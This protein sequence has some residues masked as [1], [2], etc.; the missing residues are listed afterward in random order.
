MSKGKAK[1]TLL[2]IQGLVGHKNV[3]D[4]DFLY[5]QSLVKAPGWEI[6]DRVATPDGRV[7]RYGLAKAAVKSHIGC[8]STIAQ[9]IT[10]SHPV[11]GSIGDRSLKVTVSVGAMG[12]D[13]DGVIDEDELRGGH[14][15][16]HDQA[17]AYHIHNRGIIGNTALAATG[18]EITLYLDAALVE[19][20]TA[21]DG[22]EVNGN[23]YGYVSYHDSTYTSVMGLPN[24]N[25]AAAAYFW[26]QTWGICSLPPGV[27]GVGGAVSERQLIFRSNGTI[28]SQN[29]ED[30]GEMQN[31][32]FIVEKTSLGSDGSPFLM[33]QISP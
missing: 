25:A 11:A 4:W 14:L 3:P 31:A 19:A 13:A 8:K 15:V 23:Q 30:V 7:F 9:L 2:G 18:T 28:E 24:V 1:S 16:I 26:M 27:A 5:E 6:G 32:G 33:L 17:A 12:E 10:Y 22:V 20:P 29:D 21:A